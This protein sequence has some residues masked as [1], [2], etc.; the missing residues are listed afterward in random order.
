MDQ[1]RLTLGMDLARRAGALVLDG[2]GRT[3][4]IRHKGAIDLVTEYDLRSERL[5][6][7]GIRSAFPSDAILSEEA[8]ASGET[9]TCWVI[10]PLDGTT[11]FAHGL[12][13]F[14]VSIAFWDHDRPAFGIVFDPTR[15]ELFH[16]ARGEGAWLNDQP[17][18]VSSESRLAESLLATGFAYDIRSASEDN[19]DHFAE[20]SRQALAIRRFGSAA[21]DLA[22]VAAGRYDAYWELSLYPWDWA[23][24]VLLVREAGGRMTTLDGQNALPLGMASFLASNGLVH[25]EALRALEAKPHKAPEA[26]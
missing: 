9:E 16:A 21:L 13:H 24:G 8:G 1:S 5:I 19:L 14:S 4:D 7:N 12:P 23:A 17:L 3:N 26:P 18:H 25:D 11:N 2:L 6:V 20:M 15:S 22:Y 10:D